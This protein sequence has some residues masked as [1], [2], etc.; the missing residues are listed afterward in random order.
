MPTSITATSAGG[1]SRSPAATTYGW[2]AGVDLHPEPALLHRHDDDPGAAGRHRAAR[3][4]WRCSA[5]RSPPTTSRRPAR[6]SPT[7]RPAAICSS[8]ASAAAE[9]NS[10]GARRGNHEVMMRGTFANIRIRNRMLDN[11]EGGFT[12]Y[13][14]TGETMPI[15]DAAMALQAGRHAARRHRRQGIWHRQLARLGG[16]GHR[17]ARRPRGDRREL[18]A[19]P[20]L[21]PGRHG[22]APAAVP[23]RRECREPRPRRQRDLHD[24]RRRRDRAAP[25][26]RGAGDARR[27]QR[28]SASPPA[29]ASIPTTSSNIS[30]RAASCITCCGSWQRRDAPSSS[31]S[32]SSAGPARC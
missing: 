28:A 11:V 19:H 22:R 20:P 30:A 12:R 31:R 25:G 10:Y 1:R 17:A 13:A 23:R 9:F 6:S 8:T 14:P 18:R 16:Q 2:P 29:A 24:H 3:G 27:R 15:Y 7:A 32:K 26:C 5:I 21:E 4:R